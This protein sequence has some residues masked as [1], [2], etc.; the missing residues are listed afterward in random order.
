M[1]EAQTSPAYGGAVPAPG[2]PG[3]TCY[4][5]AGGVRVSRVAAP[6][7]P[8]LLAG[9]TRQVDGRR[10]GVLSS[11]MEYPGRYSRWHVGYVDP[12]AEII[13]RGRNVC[14]R[15]LND[16]G[17]VLLPV[18]GAA[19][20]RAAGAASGAAPGPGAGPP[21]KSSSRSPAAP[22]PRRNAAAGRPS[23]PRSGRSSRP[24]PAPTSTSACTVRSATTWRSSSSRSGS[25]GRATT[26]SGTWS[27]TCRTSSTCWTASARPRSATGTSSRC[28]APRRRACRG[29][30]RAPGGRPGAGPAASVTEK[31]LPADPEPGSYARVVTAARERFA[32]GDLFEVV[33]EPRLPRGLRLAGRVLRA[34]AAPQPGAVRVLPEPRRGGVPG[35]RVSGDVRAGDRRPGGDLPDRR[36]D[37]R[38]ARGRWRTP[39]TSA[40]CSTR[41]RRSPS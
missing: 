34:A 39:R 40:R 8:A 37:R 14:A 16:R 1:Q 32:R 6:F 7:D 29:P 20:R 21:S 27:C 25:P 3:Q 10:G 5:T 11:G 30:P 33:P 23:S 36:H 24:S 2:G 35:R 18:L 12:C 17:A 13:A 22:S 9:L 41:R 4:V 19:L 15:A 38:A 31:D 28:P 26:G